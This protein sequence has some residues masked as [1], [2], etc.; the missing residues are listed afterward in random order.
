MARAGSKS[1]ASRKM[2]ELV[3]IFRSAVRK[4][5]AENRRMGVVSAYSID[6]ERVYELPSGEFTRTRPEE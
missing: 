6:G 5:R 2:D 3:S 4:A 1:K